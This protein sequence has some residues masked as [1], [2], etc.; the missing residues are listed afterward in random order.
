MARDMKFE[1]ARWSIFLVL[2]LTYILVYFH[3]MAPAV[4]SEYLMA[5]FQATG[6][7][8][9]SLSAIYFMVYAVMQ[10]PSGVL[11][12]TLGTRT[13]IV[14]GNLAAGL[15]S[16]VFALAGSFE[17]ACVGRFLVGLGVSVVFVSIMKNNAVWFPAR[18]FGLMSGVTLLIGNLGSV[19]AAGPLSMALTFLE[20]R[21]IFIGI[22]IFSLI[23]SVIGFLIVRNKPED[24]GFVSPNPVVPSATGQVDTRSW[25]QNLIQVL[26]VG[27]I[28]PCFW[29][30][31]GVTGSIYAFMGLWG[32]PYLRD[33]HGLS[34]PEAANYMTT[35]LVA[36]A[37]G[38]LFFGWFSDRIGKRKSVLIGGLIAYIFCWIVLIYANWTPGLAGMM[39]F[40]CLGFAGASFVITF[41]SAKEVIHP[42]FSGI[43]VSISNAGCFVG[44]TVIQPLFGWLAD[45]TWDGTIDNGV[46]MYSNIDYRSGLLM[47]LAFLVIGLLSSFWVQETNCRNIAFNKSGED[48]K[49]I[50]N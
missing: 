2:I 49:N 33:V 32:V 50:C 1:T 31:L 37:L 41:A 22:G 45:R 27:R 14:G 19:T 28:W 8:L 7:R 48:D 5:D 20:W 13:S 42:E 15:G 16:I 21:T 36:F 17:M 9:G 18:V 4:V 10:L 47:M 12:D 26:S 6:A 35:M 23:L 43:A 30:Q 25:W 38:A 39:L 24:M 29:V 11:A 3:R 46:R 40:G 34:R 44:A